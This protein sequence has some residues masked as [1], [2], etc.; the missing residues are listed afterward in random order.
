[1]CYVSRKPLL[2]GADRALSGMSSNLRDAHYESWRA[3]STKHAFQQ[4]GSGWNAR[5]DGRG[6]LHCQH[7]QTYWG[8]MWF[9]IASL[10]FW[11]TGSFTSNMNLTNQMNDR[12]CSSARIHLQNTLYALH[13]PKIR[14]WNSDVNSLHYFHQSS[15][16]IVLF[17]TGTQIPPRQT[18]HLQFPNCLLRPYFF[19]RVGIYVYIHQSLASSRLLPFD[20][21]NRDF[22]FTWLEIQFS[23]FSH[24]FCI[25][26]SMVLWFWVIIFKHRY[27]DFNAFQIIIL[28]DF[29]VHSKD[30][31]L[32]SPNI[33]TVGREAEAFVGINNSLTYLNASPVVLATAH[34]VLISFAHPFTPYSLI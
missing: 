21:F 25:A 3:S 7:A 22:Q 32:H 17:L 11:I 13:C 24:Y 30:W 1:M 5:Y 29:N 8:F 23:S 15:S 18:R 2:I 6:W 19:S 10:K 12:G 31:L 26:I 27:T 20:P 14:S 33:L 4:A 9:P 16:I 34:T 28:D